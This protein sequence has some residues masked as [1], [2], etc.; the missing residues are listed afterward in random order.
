MQPTS[1]ADIER[2]VQH[3]E[4]GCMPWAREVALGVLAT[5]DSVD[6]D[7]DP[8]PPLHWHSIYWLRASRWARQGLTCP[9]MPETLE[10]LKSETAAVHAT[11][12]KSGARIAGLL[13]WGSGGRLIGAIRM[14]DVGA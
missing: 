14:P 1:V 5:A 4:G 2:R 12:A 9:G 8:Y 3:L 10:A 11:I 6:D 7:P 13:F